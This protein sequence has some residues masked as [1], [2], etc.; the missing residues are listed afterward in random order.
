MPAATPHRRMDSQASI[1]SHDSIELASQAYYQSEIGAA[2]SGSGVN[3][4]E[5][6]VVQHLKNQADQ[7]TAQQRIQEKVE[8]IQKSSWLQVLE[9]ERK[10][11][12][13]RDAAERKARAARLA[14]LFEEEDVLSQDDEDMLDQGAGQREVG[15]YID[16]INTHLEV[17]KRLLEAWNENDAKGIVY[18]GAYE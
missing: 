8:A 2:P 16:K 17:E 18:E 12:E 7:Q 13:E 14:V 3:K 15:N 10:E 6:D 1:K 5:G 4:F 9:K 11:K